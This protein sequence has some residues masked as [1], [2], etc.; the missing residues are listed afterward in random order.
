M[1]R[2]NLADGGGNLSIGIGASVAQDAASNGNTASTTTN[3]SFDNT[4]PTVTISGAPA[5]VNSTAPFNVT[6][7]FSESVTGFISGDVTVTNG[8]ATN[9]SGSGSTYTVEITPNGGGNLSIGIDANVVQDASLN[10]NTASTTTNV[11]FNV[12]PTANAGNDKFVDE[13]AVVILDGSASV[14]GG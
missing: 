8:S 14:D 10:G 1:S 3:V 5:I 7:E 11:T 13:S 4:V 9:V 12:P 2:S 6:V